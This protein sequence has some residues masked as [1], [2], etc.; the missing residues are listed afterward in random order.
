M[1]R[2]ENPAGCVT[3][4][5]RTGWFRANG[6]AVRCYYG[7]LAAVLLYTLVA[8][9]LMTRHQGRSLVNTFSYFTIQS[10]VL[11]LVT[12]G[13]LCIRPDAS[14]TLWRV[15]RL[16]ALCGIT[17]TGIVYTT[18][19]A[20]Y[21]HLSGWG[22]AYN[23]VFHYF[24]PAV[25]VIGFVFVGPRLRFRGGDFLYMVW[26]VFWLVYTMIRGAV[27]QPQFRG[28]GE[29]VSNY[30]YRFL[31]IDRVSAGEIVGSV[32]LIGV[33]LVACGFAYLYGERWLESK[34]QYVSETR[35]PA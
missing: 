14:G 32:I 22:L 3:E 7:P 25:S 35:L 31:D 9:C 30:P 6:P 10:N 18:V 13:V 23:Y 16:A 26:P 15:L 21:V 24:M 5:H 29:P 11:V 28:F 33:L 1:D 2:L 17:V 34:L 19:L 12:S 20:P 8:Q 4:H 27:A